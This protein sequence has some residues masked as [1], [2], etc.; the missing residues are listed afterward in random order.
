MKNLPAS[1]LDSFRAK[2]LALTS[3]AGLSGMPQ[4]SIP[5]AAM[6]GLPVG[7]SIIAPRG[8]DIELLQLTVDLAGVLLPKS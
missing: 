4:V 8:K 5:C 3:I 2:A 1:E 7:L 6:E